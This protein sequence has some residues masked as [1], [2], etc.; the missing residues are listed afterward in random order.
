MVLPDLI[1]IEDAGSRFIFGVIVDVF[2]EVITVEITNS[3]FWQWKKGDYL[4]FRKYQV[5]PEDDTCKVV[6]LSLF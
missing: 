1:R 2:K 3:T 6:Q 5:L 4:F